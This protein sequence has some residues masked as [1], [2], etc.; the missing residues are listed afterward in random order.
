MKIQDGTAAADACSAGL[1]FGITKKANMR[2]PASPLHASALCRHNGSGA[3][4]DITKSADLDALR[5]D[6]SRYP[7]RGEVVTYIASQ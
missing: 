6:A 3:L 2:E 4:S 1:P 7:D 5:R